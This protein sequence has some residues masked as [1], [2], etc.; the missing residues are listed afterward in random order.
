VS[1]RRVEVGDFTDEQLRVQR[2]GEALHR[3]GASPAGALE[4]LAALVEDQTWERLADA[5]GRSFKGRFRDFVE[6]RSP[7]GLGYDADQLPKLLALR[8]PHESHVPAVALRMAAMRGEVE[9]LLWAE[10]PASLPIGTPGLSKDAGP[11]ANDRGTNIKP[12]T[13]DDARHVVARLK[14]DDPELAA[15]VV[16]G[17]ISPNA[18]AR[19]KGWRKP[20]IILSTPEKVADSIRKHMPRDARRQLAELL[21]DEDDAQRSTTE[22][23]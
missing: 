19:E 13:G 23:R 1:T 2:A 20:R 4:L 18:A 22:E 8:H 5:K 10:V 15:K 9:H 6:T 3:D 21:L 11:D 17:E 12:S 7:F 16:R 14:R